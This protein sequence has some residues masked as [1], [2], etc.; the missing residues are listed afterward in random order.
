MGIDLDQIQEE[1]EHG[2]G[3]NELPTDRKSHDDEADG[4]EK[5]EK[6][7]EAGEGTKEDEPEI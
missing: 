6:D 7:I 1:D 2:A 3:T 4:E 5:G